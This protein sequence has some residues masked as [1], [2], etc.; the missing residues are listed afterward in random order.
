M[1]PFIFQYISLLFTTTPPGR[2]VLTGSTNVKG[3]RRRL[4]ANLRP[5]IAVSLDWHLISS[6]SIIS[7]G[8]SAP[9]FSQKIWWVIR[10]DNNITKE[11]TLKRYLSQPLKTSKFLQSLNEKRNMLLNNELLS[12][13]FN[14]RFKSLLHVDRLETA[15]KAFRFN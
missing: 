6:R 14:R 4:Q 13:V 12:C 1:L 2:F 5:L 10:D 9:K 8:K 7:P 11:E 15:L 3:Q